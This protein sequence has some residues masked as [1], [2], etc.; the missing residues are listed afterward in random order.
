MGSPRHQCFKGVRDARRYLGRVFFYSGCDDSRRR[1]GM[2]AGAE[3]S[4]HD[5]DD[6][7]PFAA[8]GLS[9]ELSHPLATE[10]QQLD[11]QHGGDGSLSKRLLD[12]TARLPDELCE[13]LAVSL[14]KW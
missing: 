10:W 9:L 4:D 5:V 13:K 8:G 11:G 12:A 7:L 6:D 3:F 14:T 2:A 1:A